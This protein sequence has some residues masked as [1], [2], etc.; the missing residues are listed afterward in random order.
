MNTKVSS[1][2]ERPLTQFIDDGGRLTDEAV[3]TTTQTLKNNPIFNDLGEQ[4]KLLD[5]ELE[6]LNQLPTKTSVDQARL[7]KLEQQLA[8]LENFEKQ[9][10]Q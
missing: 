5:M 8:E 4:K 10:L 1:S 6:R 9:L 7:T 3:E 2:L